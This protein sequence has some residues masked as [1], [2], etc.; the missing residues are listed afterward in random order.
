MKSLI[1]A[2]LLTLILLPAFS[3]LTAEAA[4]SLRINDLTVTTRIVRG[5]PIDS[6]HRISSASVRALYC[7]SSINSTDRSP[8]VIRHAWYRNNEKIAEHE[9][10]VEGER[11]RS[12]SKQTVER[13]DSGSWRVELLD[14]GGKILKTVRFSM[15]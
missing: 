5:K 1:T 12:H 14:S 4:G 6:V 3:P 11:W 9:L 8:T 15:N 13:K 10:P 7:F 2:I